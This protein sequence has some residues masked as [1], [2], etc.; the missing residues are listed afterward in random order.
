MRCSS[1]RRT[2]CH[3]LYRQ[4][5]PRFFD[6]AY[7]PPPTTNLQC[8]HIKT[9]IDQAETV[10][11]RVIKFAELMQSVWMSRND[12]ERRVRLVC[13]PTP[14][15]IPLTNQMTSFFLLS[16]IFK[17]NGTSW[18]SMALIMMRNSNLRISQRIR[19]SPNV[20]G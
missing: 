17:P 13:P 4:L 2:E 5:L 8:V 1:S 7:V 6:H 11:R 9:R 14:D 3:D 15:E 19:R 16:T 12:Y 10:A 18:S 20:N